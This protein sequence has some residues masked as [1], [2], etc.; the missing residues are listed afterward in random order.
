[1]SKR[2]PER[3]QLIGALM[4]CRW[5]TLQPM[6]RQAASVPPTARSNC[7]MFELVN[8]IGFTPDDYFCQVELDKVR[9]DNIGKNVPSELEV[10][11]SLASMVMALKPKT[12]VEIGCYHCVTTTQLGLAMKAS[13]HEGRIYAVDIDPSALKV[14][15]EIL[16]NHGV[17]DCVELVL[18]SCEERGLLEAVPE[19]DLVFIDGDHSY[20]GVKRDW[21]TWSGRISKRG[22]AAFH[23]AVSWP[24]VAKL[25]GEILD[26][27]HF[28]VFTCATSY[29]SGLSIVWRR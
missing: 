14:G 28:K 17:L 15:Q 7:S 18:G 13:A 10:A 24:G 11:A 26:S 12:V 5:E 19:A 3:I 27:G 29:G 1:M 25:I 20:E 23:D 8:H 16:K 9:A 2:L 6:F 22:I 21:E 4:G